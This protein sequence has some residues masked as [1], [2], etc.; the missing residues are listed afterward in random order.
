MGTAVEQLCSVVIFWSGP[1]NETV[2]QAV[3]QD[4]LVV[5]VKSPHSTEGAALATLESLEAGTIAMDGQ[6]FP[7]KLQSF[8][9]SCFDSDSHGLLNILPSRLGR[10]TLAR[11]RDLNGSHW[12]P[13]ERPI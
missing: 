3:S 4:S 1:V 11:N 5:L 8:G 6:F 12:K 7:V 2:A 10:L 13:H 9:S